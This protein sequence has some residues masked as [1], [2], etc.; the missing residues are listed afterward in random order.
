MQDVAC[1]MCVCVCVYGVRRYKEEDGGTGSR[2]K[3][4]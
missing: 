3:A 1:N 2:F 4:V